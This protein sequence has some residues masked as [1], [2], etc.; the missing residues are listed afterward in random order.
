MNTDEDLNKRIN[1]MMEK[2]KWKST[3]N[4]VNLLASGGTTQI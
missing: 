3:K 2:W 1:Q 4:H